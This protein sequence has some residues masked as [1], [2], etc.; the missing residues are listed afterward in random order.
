MNEKLEIIYDDCF[1]GI[2]SY[3]FVNIPETDCGDSYYV[4]VEMLDVVDFEA[5]FTEGGTKIEVEDF[6]KVSGVSVEE[7]EKYLKD[8][9]KDFAD[10]DD[11]EKADLF[12][13]SSDDF[14]PYDNRDS[15]DYRY[16][17]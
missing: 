14:I 16:G 13:L 4:N 12:N 7:L 1:D 9:E 3:R 15:N 8:T 10:M 2:A 17:Y 5:Y 11:N 6:A